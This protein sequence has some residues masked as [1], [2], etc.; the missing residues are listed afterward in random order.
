[1]R[2]TTMAARVVAR[3]ICKRYYSSSANRYVNQMRKWSIKR[4]DRAQAGWGVDG[5]VF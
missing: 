4:Y 2:P 3:D 1:M 5:N